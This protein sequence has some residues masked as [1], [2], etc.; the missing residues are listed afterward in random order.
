[1]Q[2]RN[3]SQVPTAAAAGQSTHTAFPSAPHTTN[4]PSH[5]AASATSTTPTRPNP[6]PITHP[7]P[8]HNRRMARQ[9]SEAFLLAEVFVAPRQT[10]PATNVHLAEAP[11]ASLGAAPARAK[12][13]YG[14]A[15]TASLVTASA[16]VKAHYGEAAAASLVTA[17]AS[18]QRL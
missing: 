3:K 5:P 4:W 14:E 9:C 15:A 12:A 2:P 18:G 11:A 6:A 7:G 1:M 8:S 17:S 13:H 16:R 10:H